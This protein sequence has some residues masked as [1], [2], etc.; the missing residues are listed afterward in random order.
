M[1][2]ATY[3]Y[4]EI[5][6]PFSEDKNPSWVVYGLRL[7]GSDE[8]RYVGIT[9]QK[10][11]ERI[12]A[13]RA[14]ALKGARNQAVYFWI[15]KYGIDKI[16]CDILELCPPNDRLYIDEAECYW[17]SSIK[18]FG[19]RLL[20]LNEGGNGN[21]GYKHS[22][23]I[24]EKLSKDKLGKDGWSEDVRIAYSK[25]YSGDK[26]YWYGRRGKDVPWYG[27][28]YSVD[29]RKAMS[30]GAKFGIHSSKPESHVSYGIVN[31]RCG[32]CREKYE[33]G[34]ITRYSTP[35]EIRQAKNKYL[36]S[37]D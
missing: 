4:T 16:D 27:Q 24:K 21:K 18:S 19:H 20:N 29:R 30:L 32:K 13:H 9:Q 22:T 33:S 36:D 12:R 35:S 11:K 7:K 17:I 34:E 31:M 3:V 26:S 25:S 8:Y 10:V 37:I 28:K 14:Y 6:N 2:K 1:I 15:R 23:E 5:D